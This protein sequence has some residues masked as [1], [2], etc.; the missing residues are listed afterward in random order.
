MSPNSKVS[1]HLGHPRLLVCRDR[2]QAL[3]AWGTPNQGIAALPASLGAWWLPAWLGM[4]LRGGERLQLA[5]ALQHSTHVILQGSDGAGHAGI[6]LHRQ[7]QGEL[8]GA[9]S[10]L[11]SSGKAKICGAQRRALLRGGGAGTQHMWQR[12]LDRAGQAEHGL[13]L[14]EDPQGWHGSLSTLSPNGQQ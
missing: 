5:Q 11:L 4:Y 9:P 6:Q 2:S 8:R 10:V 13:M 12:C 7:P 3:P 14:R 1:P